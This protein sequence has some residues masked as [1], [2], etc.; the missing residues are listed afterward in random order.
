MTFR[1]RISTAPLPQHSPL[2]SR[3]QAALYLGISEQTLA[4]WAS[5]NRNSLAHVKIGSLTKYQQSDLDQFIRDNRVG[6]A[7]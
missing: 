3:K 4:T 7:K 6:G 5:T 2:L 1:K